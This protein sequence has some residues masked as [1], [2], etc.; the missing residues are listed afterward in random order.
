LPGRERHGDFLA[1][2]NAAEVLE[3]A[4]AVLVENDPFDGQLAAFLRA[5]EPACRLYGLR[6][7]VLRL[8]QD[9]RQED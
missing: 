8:H 2:L 1:V 7:P 4:D 6:R 9:G 5:A 3:I